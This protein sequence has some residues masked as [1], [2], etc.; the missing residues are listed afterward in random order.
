MFGKVWTWI[1]DN[2]YSAATRGMQRFVND[3]QAPAEEGERPTLQLV[4]RQ[5]EAK[6]ETPPA[7]RRK[8]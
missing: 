1:E 4:F 7:K 5:P 6:D 3:M 2:V 8:V